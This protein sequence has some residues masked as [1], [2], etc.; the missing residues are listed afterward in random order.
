MKYKLYRVSEGQALACM[1]P[2]VMS[3]CK[4]PAASFYDGAKGPFY[5]CG[6]CTRKF[7]M[8]RPD[9]ELVESN[10]REMK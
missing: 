6:K 5:R 8:R 10:E 9:F 7:L 4:K 2:R 3:T 1:I